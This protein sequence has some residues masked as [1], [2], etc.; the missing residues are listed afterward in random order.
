[1]SVTAPA[2]AVN[3]GYAYREQVGAAQAGQTVLDYLAR[4]YTH[5]SQ[6]QWRDRLDRGEVSVDGRRA[7][8]AAVLHGGQIIVWARPPWREAEVPLGWCRATA[9]LTPLRQ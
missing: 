1:M 6:S 7:D 3:E 8:P 5:S 4:R 9:K 2:S